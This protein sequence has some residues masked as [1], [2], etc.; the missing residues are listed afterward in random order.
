MLARDGAASYPH[1]TNKRP[2]FVDALCPEG[3]AAQSKL[4]AEDMGR[5]ERME[6]GEISAEKGEEAQP[7][8]P[9]AEDARLGVLAGIKRQV[10]AL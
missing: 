10:Q 2:S 6:Q 5:H 9:A 3:I 1:F 8:R 7:A 4:S